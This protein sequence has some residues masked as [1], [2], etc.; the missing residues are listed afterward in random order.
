M[1]FFF[2]LIFLIKYRQS[3]E[4]IAEEHHDS[5][6]PIHQIRHLPHCYV[7][8]SSS[9][10]NLKT[11]LS[12]QLQISDAI[13]NSTVFLS[14]LVNN[15]DTFLT[16]FFSQVDSYGHQRALLPH[17]PMP[18]STTSEIESPNVEKMLH[19][20]V[21]ENDTGSGDN[22]QNAPS[23]NLVKL[24]IKQKSN[25]TDTCMDV[26][27]GCWPSDSSSSDNTNNNNTVSGCGRMRKRSMND[28]GKGSALSRHDEEEVP[29]EEEE[30][31]YDSLDCTAVNE[32]QRQRANTAVSSPMKVHK[33]G[34][35]KDLHLNIRHQ[36]KHPALYNLMQPVHHQKQLNNSINN[37]NNNHSHSD[38]SHTSENLTQIF[39]INKSR[40]ETISKSIQTSMIKE[41]NIRIVPPS[42]LAKLNQE[43][44]NRNK[45]RVFVVYPNYALPDLGFV[46]TAPNELILSPI[47][48]KD[49]FGKMKSRRPVS[50]NDVDA[51]KS[52]QYGHVI[53]WKSLM[54]LLP[55]EYR[56][57]LKNIPEA[58]EVSMDASLLANKP[59]FSM[60]PPIRTNRAVSCDCAYILSNTQVTS[61]SS[62]GSSSQPPSSGYR[63]SSTILTDSDMNDATG[64][65]MY[66]YQYDEAPKDRPPSGRTPKGILRRANTARSAKNT[67]KRS[68]MFEGGEYVMTTAEKRRSLQEPFYATQI[69]EDYI[70]EMEGHETRMNNAKRN[71]LP[72]YPKQREEYLD[73]RQSKMQGIDDVDFMMPKNASHQKRNSVLDHAHEIEARIRAERFLINVPKSDLKHYAEIA[74]ILET[75]PDTGSGFNSIHLRNEVSRALSSQ[76]PQSQISTNHMNNNRK[77]VQFTKPTAGPSPKVTSPMKQRSPITARLLKPNELRFNTPPNSPNMSVM[78]SK[79][80]SPTSKQKDAEK[81]K[82]E[83]IQ[84]NRFKRLQIQWELLS[85]DAAQ[86]AM[87]TKSGGTTP[88]YA[89]KSR[90]PRPVSYPAATR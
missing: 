44:R 54:T 42:F 88:L 62:G 19:E 23:F 14:L 47:G 35:Y 89:P 49:G 67:G 15:F 52:R 29:R 78:T 38:T 27:S 61:S 25:S 11:I 10:P 58:N 5:M 64:N 51:M 32:E 86:R 82:Q 3:Q 26:S 79:K 66:V 46:S 36:L 50:L 71:L 18:I 21:A 1:I 75:V 30:F 80:Q 8:K 76:Q 24:F 87:E 63:G 41:Q 72:N 68:S 65:N 39:N 13:S 59:L 33:Q 40:T 53:D 6:H 73:H 55:T 57:I 81:E 9:M 84:S 28:S 69:I 74:N 22:V 4:D 77:Q 31:Q 34:N 70:A 43:E 2:K 16:I 17:Y 85:K 12:N 7:N 45:G 90:I 56:K 60:T 83:K 20:S 48:Y 37:N